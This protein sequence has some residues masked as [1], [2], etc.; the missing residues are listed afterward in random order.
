[1]LEDHVETSVGNWMEIIPL[2]LWAIYYSTFIISLCLFPSL[3]LLLYILLGI[4]NH[5]QNVSE[6]R[7]KIETGA[8]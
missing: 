7:P 1:M 3:G 6:L 5:E 2:R 8:K 4:K